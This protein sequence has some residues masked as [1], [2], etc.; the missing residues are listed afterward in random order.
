MSEGSQHLE[1]LAVHA[2]VQPDPSTGAIMTPIYA[3]STYVQTSPG[4]HLG[5]EYSRTKNPTRTVLEANLA[6]LEGGRYGFATASGCNAT[7]VLLHLLETGDHVVCVDDVY[8]G[9]SRLFRTVWSRHGVNV[10]FADLTNRPVSEFVTAKT[11]MIC[12]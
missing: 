4:T 1:T 7:D 2:G 12:T 3:T 11:K 9:T 10:T 6:A 8:G 5:Y